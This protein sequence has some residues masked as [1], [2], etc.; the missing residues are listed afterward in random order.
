M[1]GRTPALVLEQAVVAG[2]DMKNSSAGSAARCP[3]LVAY[4]IP[5]GI[6]ASYEETTLN[7]IRALERRFS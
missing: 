3:M 1:D 2:L 4:G 6:A 5:G 7:L